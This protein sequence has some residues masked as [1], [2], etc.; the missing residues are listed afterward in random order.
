MHT[1]LPQI[2]LNLGKNMHKMRILCR[3]VL[4][5]NCIEQWQDHW[6]PLLPHL[7]AMTR[8]HGQLGLPEYVKLQIII[9]NI[10]ITSDSIQHIHTVIHSLNS[11]IFMNNLK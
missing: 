8:M 1:N 2:V 6:L 10:N 11:F 4:R 7:C 5:R 9:S 3:R